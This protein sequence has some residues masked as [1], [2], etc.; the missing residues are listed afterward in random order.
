ME[1]TN[2]EVFGY[3][4]LAIVT[5]IGVIKFLVTAM[6]QDTSTIYQKDRK[7]RR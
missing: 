3:V 4:V 7:N 2:M 1:P 5:W 6:K